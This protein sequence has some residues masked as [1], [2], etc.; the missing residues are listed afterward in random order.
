[1]NSATNGANWVDEM[2]QDED[3]EALDEVY[4]KLVALMEQYGVQQN[5]EQA[6]AAG[7][8]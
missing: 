5:P 8:Q 2:V 3:W 6:A 7:S 1:M 4:E